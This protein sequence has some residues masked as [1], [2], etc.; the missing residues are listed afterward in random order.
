M[1]LL[2]SE[3]TGSQG[4][5]GGDN[6]EGRTFGE[7][8][9]AR[10]KLKP[11]ALPLS[12][13]AVDTRRGDRV[14]L[15]LIPAAALSQTTNVR[16]ERELE[17]L[18]GPTCDA[19][20]RQTG[21]DGDWFYAARPFVDGE[22][23]QDCLRRGPLT[24]AETLAIARGLMSALERLHT[25]D[26]LHRNVKPA[27]L[28]LSAEHDGGALL[29]DCALMPYEP[30][31]S[32]VH[33][34]P[35]SVLHYL[36]PEQAGLL[37]AAVGPAAD[38]YAAGVVIYECLAGRPP[39]T[40]DTVSQVLREHMTAR[41][42]PLRSRA[43][44]VPRSLDEIVQRLLR[45]DPRDRYQSA[46]AVATDL[47][48]LT[49]AL[50][51]G[52][53]DPPMVVGMHDRRG[54]LTE[55]AFV[56]RQQELG[57]LDQ[58]L[59][60]VREGQ[61]NLVVILAESGG[62]KS[63]LLSEV[64]ERAALH[65][66]WVIR[67]Q[68]VHEAGALPFQLLH[69]L[70]NEVV[71]R[72]TVPEFADELRRRLGDS[73]DA[74]CAALPELANILQPSGETLL[75]PEA[76]GELR[77]IHA[78]AD[79]LDALGN[80]EQ[81]AVVL[82]DDCQWADGLTVHLLEQWSRRSTESRH[83]V[84]IAAFRRDEAEELLSPD[85]MPSAEWLHLAPFDA[86]D[87]RLLIES[88]AGPLPAEAVEVVT[89][90]T[91][92][93]P[94]MA[95]ALLRGL[96]EC[97]ALVADTDG[98]WRIDELAMADVRSS[99]HAT[100]LLLRRLQLLPKPTLR[101]LSVGAILGKEFSAKSAASL[102]EEEPVRVETALEEAR[103]RHFL[104]V[105]ES[106]GVCV[107]VHDRIRE[108]LLEL[109][110]VA[111]RQ[112]LHREAALHL[113]I[114]DPERCFD[115][116]Y[117]YDAA[118][119]SKSALNYALQAADLARSR[120]ALEF[121]EQQYRIAQRGAG[122]AAV[123]VRFH[124]AKGL[125]DV[126][127][128]RGRYDAA[129]E[130]LEHAAQLASGATPRAQ[131]QGKLGELAFKRGDMA[132]ATAAFEAALQLLGRR[133]PRNTVM[134]FAW[135]GWEALVQTMH[136]LFPRWLV[137]RI[138]R[139]PDEA[140]LLGLRLFSRLAHGYWF[141]SGKFQVLWAHLRG[142]NLAERYAPTLE[143]A[144]SYSEHAPAMSLIPWYSRGEDY[145]RRSL[146]IRKSFGDLWGQGQ[147]LHFYGVV[148]YTACRFREC[149]QKCREAVRLL[150]RTGD[151]WEVHIA[152]YQIAASLYRLGDVGGAIREAKRIHES[153]L[154]LGDE[155]ASGISLDVWA[156]AA[157]GK[158]PEEILQ[159]EI[160]RQR[161]DA[162]GTA[163]V[164][165]AEGVRLIGLQ[166]FREAAEVFK[167][168][169]DTTRKSGVLNTYTTPNLAWLATARRRLAEQGLIYTPQ[170]R[171]QLLRQADSAARQALRAA[172]KFAN[173]L[174]HALREV[175][176]ISAMRGK[177]RKAQRFFAAS[178]QVAQSH[179]ARLE[180][181][182]TLHA[183]SRVGLELKW[184]DA[185][186]DLAVAQAELKSLRAATER[187]DQS[188]PVPT[189]S[190]ADRFDSVLTS[191]RRI[192]SALTADGV[193]QEMREAALRLL[194]AEYCSILT[195]T[196][197][198]GLDLAVG[199][200][201]P[202]ARDELARFTS[203]AGRAVVLP[204][205]MRE[206]FT[207]N[208]QTSAARSALC[209]PICERG[210]I[211]AVMYVAHGS[212]D[213]LFGADEERLADFVAALGGA[214]LENAENFRQLQRLNETL[215]QRVAERTA[216]AETRARELANTNRQLEATARQLRQAQEQLRVAKDAAESA[217]NAK[218]D[219]LATMSHEIRTPMNGILGMV[220][221]A[222]ATSL[223]AV[224]RNYLS[225]VRQSADRLMG[226][227][228]EI[229]DLSKIEAGKL[230]LERVDF[231]LRDTVIEA[232]QMMAIRAQKNGLEFVV[233]IAPHLPDRVI[234]DP[235][236]LRQ[237][238][239]NLIGNAI[240][241]T[242]DGEVVLDVE[243]ASLSD[244]HIGLHVSVRD[245]G[246]G[247]PAD[248]QPL[249]FQSFRQ[250]DSS[251]TR[252]FGGS[253]LGLTICSKLVQLMGGQI[254]V[255]S[256][257]GKG[258]TF[259]FTTRLEISDSAEECFADGPAVPTLVVSSVASSRRT[260]QE[261][262][263]AEGWPVKTAEDGLSALEQLVDAATDDPV[264]VVLVDIAGPQD[265]MWTLV[266]QLLSGEWNREGRLAV[267][268][269]MGN[270]E[271]LT[272]CQELGIHDYLLKP[273]HP[274]QLWQFLTGPRDALAIGDAPPAEPEPFV[275]RRVL[276]VEDDPVNQDVATG[277]LELRG[278]KVYVVG[279]GRDAVETALTQEFDVIL[280]DL[281]MPDMDGLQAAT[282]IR[283]RESHEKPRV[284][285]VA[286]TAHVLHDFV[287]RCR[288]AG[289]DSY[290]TKPID[291]DQLF[292]TVEHPTRFVPR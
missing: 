162:Q 283:R 144:Q 2:P 122:D 244:T 87:V 210:R 124:I 108:E 112:R 80:P 6:L 188:T 92:G 24:V 147:S 190:L 292:A 46:T 148:L 39:F 85:R 102:A 38:L 35:A 106:D 145:A 182:L 84:V 158:I 213:D 224:Q 291:P 22:S 51:Q 245:T 10:E 113:Q 109:L 282:E 195:L 214:A 125:G 236:R 289:M 52:Q 196:E 218:S 45:K 133:I 235:C 267:I 269:P 206:F 130:L 242:D 56:G 97:G 260:L 140:Y 273:F 161:H 281:E 215:E 226:L 229:L 170:Q 20:F 198:G 193:F 37:D 59:R 187:L 249:I 55:P 50:E 247:I 31:D 17:V 70:A 100:S 156:R 11:D 104:W 7:T 93:C 168:A 64:A 49:A 280:M 284:P 136:S 116:A 19:A 191:G 105:N 27:N 40:G 233:R 129:A 57:Q 288:A 121:A 211:A 71:A 164:L 94:F 169:L 141:V 117:H 150:E 220:E 263:T 115:I 67:G 98:G 270:L 75:G 12:F 36:A 44:G 60:R 78:L 53:A 166:Q 146:E 4:L 197:A 221:L 205:D 73:T 212:I 83:V 290:V 68:G 25:Q 5:G 201:L 225:L 21:Q 54:T 43:K 88:M 171:R 95:T 208:G 252:R 119:D 18:S 189:L 86:D 183:R 231:Q 219:F 26:V 192:A 234:G 61:G 3:L 237:V 81:P 266:E 167:Q 114:H 286:M 77:S 259:H 107:F 28:I 42:P 203:Q 90:L 76:F 134:L 173:D 41:V 278:H 96:V 159:R 257:Q 58:Q 228:N 139:P 238:I 110:P 135:L 72:A 285:I 253:G 14:V 69:G 1:A 74:A 256:E 239:I 179:E 255:E 127:M 227:L 200:E 101:L 246:I 185:E 153:G 63:R 176:L 15:K 250:A 258:S 152:R 279:N 241:F 34:W 276:L 243:M 30:G 287:H 128:L 165:L 99:R 271:C 175:A 204:P 8:F 29:V 9:R 32:A 251:T 209:T 154:E 178:L 181:A 47:D 275:P 223:T 248:Q 65:G 82:L 222:L 217:N 232:A 194:R 91:E 265:R 160:R 180:Y 277:L 111:E 155:Q 149:V 66:C 177:V 254:W 172:K 62:G 174:P 216:A 89:R 240:K 23:L 48:L 103:R 151:Y 120:H 272:R 186:H 132:R 142:M 261:M 138:R 202:L 131:V 16:S 126:L 262:F 137:G 118:G 33:S 184:R 157:A 13:S 230:E 207:A 274:R 264:A 163:Q 143:L 123:S 79:L 268:V 199:S